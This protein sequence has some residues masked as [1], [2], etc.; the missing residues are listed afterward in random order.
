MGAV[1]LAVDTATGRRVA[2]KVLNAH[3]DRS[4]VDRFRAEVRA[5]AELDHPHIVTVFAAHLD[6]P[7]PHFTME[8]VP[9]GTL[10]GF[11][12]GAARWSRAPPPPCSRPLPGPRTRPTSETSSTAT[13]SRETCS[14]RPRSAGGPTLRRPTEPLLSRPRH[15]GAPPAV[16]VPKLSDFGLAKRTDRDQGLTTG[17]GVVGTPGFMAPEQ[18]NGGAITP[19]TDVYGLGATLYHVLTGRPPFEG[20]VHRVLAQVADADPPRVRSLRPAVPVDLEAVVHKC[21]EK[22]P[23]ARYATAAEVAAELDRFAGGE[24]VLARPLTPFR[25]VRRAVVRH[26]RQLGRVTAAALA[27]VAAALLGVAVGNR[28]R[29]PVEPAP[30]PDPLEEIQKEL[31]AGEPVILI[32]ATGEPRWHRWVRGPVLFAPAGGR[33][34]ACSYKALD[35]AM[36]DLCPDPM[37]DSYRLRAELCHLDVVGPGGHSIGLY[38]GRQ[39]AIGNDGWRAEVCLNVEFTETP[40]VAPLGSARLDQVMVTESPTHLPAPATRGLLGAPFTQADAL[41]GPWR[42]VEVEVSPRGVKAWLGLRGE[43]PVPFG[44][45]TADAVRRSFTASNESSD[46]VGPAHGINLPAWTPRGAIG[47]WSI[48]SAVAVRNLVVSPLK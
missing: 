12:G 4:A 35:L 27:L 32:G 44:E 7:V 11:V 1:Y 33:G 2:V 18:V 3:G 29:V 30:P 38:F 13:S 34:G 23:A 43:K 26:R 39:S 47:L 9:G 10:A 15:R 41:P 6:R 31:A 20:E 16:L 36:L 25:R 5:L 21:L 22:D 40:K 45:L 17:G 42:T 8:H 24:P 28:S 19:R 37:T 48:N 14:W 46:T